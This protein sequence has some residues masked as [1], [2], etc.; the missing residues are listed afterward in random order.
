MLANPIAAPVPVHRALPRSATDLALILPG[1]AGFAALV[2]LVRAKRT[3][4][5]DLALSLRIQAPPE[6]V[7]ALLDD[8]RKLRLW[9]PNI[10]ETRYPGGKPSPFPIMWGPAAA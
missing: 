4:A 6:K 8:E 1:I 7:W 3:Q 2:A 9:L 5:A 10:V